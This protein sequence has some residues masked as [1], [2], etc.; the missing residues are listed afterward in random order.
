MRARASVMGSTG[1]L[2][3]SQEIKRRRRTEECKFIQWRTRLL[4]CVRG[5]SPR[6]EKVIGI[7]LSLQ[8]LLCDTITLL[9]LAFESIPST[10]STNWIAISINN[11][12]RFYDICHS[13]N[14]PCTGRRSNKSSNKWKVERHTPKSCYQVLSTTASCIHPRL[15]L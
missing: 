14:A 12:R 6:T 5:S 7:H 3:P 1:Q 8:A 10:N 4:S 11:H 9:D 13:E 15:A 2:H